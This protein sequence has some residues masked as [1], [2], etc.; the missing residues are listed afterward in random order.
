MGLEETTK[1]LDIFLDRIEALESGIGSLSSTNKSLKASQDIVFAS[2]HKVSG[3]IEYTAEETENA[4]KE[5]VKIMKAQKDFNAEM[6]KVTKSLEKQKSSFE[7]FEELMGKMGSSTAKAVGVFAGFTAMMGVTT[8]S[9]K[10]LAEA[11]MGY[12]KALFDLSAKQNAVGSSGKNLI[13][14]IESISKTT[15][16]S[17]KQF[18]EFASTIQKSF[19]GLRPSMTEIAKLS[20]TLAIQVGGSFESQKEAA[21]SLISI[22]SQFPA[23][24]D[25]ISQG[26]DL[27]KK[28]NE[29]R[30]T[31][32]DEKRVSIIRSEVMATQQML[33][34]SSELKGATASYLTV[35][36][37]AEKNLSKILME[38][39]KLSKEMENAQIAFFKTVQPLLLSATKAATKILEVTEKYKTA[40]IS[41]A[42]AAPIMQG[43]I[44]LT[45][46]ATREQLKLNLAMLKNP[47]ILLAAAIA[48]TIALYVQ[49][50]KAQDDGLKSSIRESEHRKKSKQI[51]KESLT[52]TKEQRKE[53]L[54]QSKE[55]SKAIV[56][57]K[58]SIEYA[59]EYADMQAEILADIKK[60]SVE[61]GKLSVQM[62]KVRA[63]AAIQLQIVDKMTESYQA[64]VNLMANFGG[65]DEGAMK[66]VISMATQG[67]NI[68]ENKLKASIENAKA[69][70]SEDYGIKVDIDEESP[71]NEQIQKLRK[72]YEEAIK[73]GFK[74]EDVETKIGNVLGDQMDWIAKQEQSVKSQV[75]YAL[76]NVKAMEEYTT[77]SEARLNTERQLMEIAQFGMGASVSMMQKQVDLAYEMMSMYEKTNSELAETLG[78][79]QRIGKQN[80]E[81]IKSAKTI[82]E[83]QRMA[84]DLSGGEVD[85]KLK[86]LSF[87]KEN[88]DLTKKSMEQQIKIY[89]LTKEVREGYLD[90]VREMS[91]G[92]GEFEKIIGTQEMG[93]TQL[94]KYVDQFSKGALN[95]MKTGGLQSAGTTEKGV[96]TEVTGTFSAGGP[97]MSFIGGRQEAERNKRISGFQEAKDRYSQMRSGEGGPSEVGAALGA[98]EGNQ[99]LRPAQEQIAIDK[100]GNSEV[101]LGLDKVEKA[102]RGTFDPINQALITGS[103]RVGTNEKNNT[104][105]AFPLAAAGIQTRIEARRN[106]PEYKNNSVFREAYEKDIQRRI[107]ESS[108]A[109]SGPIAS[110]RRSGPYGPLMTK[111]KTEEEEKEAGYQKALEAH[112]KT[113]EDYKKASQ[114]LQA[115]QNTERKARF[116]FKD[117]EGSQQQKVKAN[118]IWKNAKKEE[119]KLGKETLEARTNFLKTKKALPKVGSYMQDVNPYANFGSVSMETASKEPFMEPPKFKLDTTKMSRTKGPAGSR[120]LT[121]A[122]KEA[123]KQGE[124]GEIAR[125]MRQDVGD[126]Q[127]GKGESKGDYQKRIRSEVTSQF[128]QIDMSKAS[129]EEIDKLIQARDMAE[130]LSYSKDNLS[131]T[132]AKA[133]AMEG[134][135]KGYT[136]A[137]AAKGQEASAQDQAY[138]ASAKNAAQKDAMGFNGEEVASGTGVCSGRILVELSADLQGTIQEMKNIV[139]SLNGAASARG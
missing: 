122:E 76:R 40:I 115:A 47:I 21:T 78:L 131:P 38:R 138:A 97:M 118:L 106:T 92:L 20:N 119:E 58:T 16:L 110:M 63:N 84:N 127:M 30:G 128:A 60:Q 103:G 130:K 41:L 104:S 113:S 108:T 66:A 71:V 37:S 134:N 94:M 125:G 91:S 53:F 90:A 117:L 19:V 68:A 28:I 18:I 111:P 120:E 132:A 23:L 52:L 123:L 49:A 54:E 12:T 75:N 61:S 69:S 22:Q 27:I 44:A 96:G 80:V 56:S 74:R 81:R 73:L 139:I 107:E 82:N 36:T 2:Y 109:S 62:D 14:T 70:L 137:A 46:V 55:K 48:G 34:V 4:R 1:R 124:I 64:Q 33:G 79:N 42:V 95:T 102:I 83:V 121:A 3:A 99:Y 65:I 7:K 5:I 112:K 17:Q 10:G 57:E 11:G 89:E 116:T 86:I 24:Y 43:I 67:L 114:K 45:K 85:L 87:W 32:E 126:L 31:A 136:S 135:Q 15:N 39:Q 98:G 6:D 9:L 93:V 51:F 72:G 101:V 88:Q 13:Y 129:G 133:M 100:E 59:E 105:L 8:F 35:R 29:G 77:A 26:L 50:Q 25:K